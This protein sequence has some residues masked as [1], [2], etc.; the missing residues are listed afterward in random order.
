MEIR[1]PSHAVMK[2]T[3]SALPRAHT[4][5]VN[6]AT[7]LR[8]EAHVEHSIGLVQRQEGD[9]LCSTPRISMPYKC[10]MQYAVCSMP[11]A[12]CSMQ[13]AVCRMQYAV[14]SMQYAVQMGHS[15]WCDAASWYRTQS[16]SASLKHV[17]KPARCGHLGALMQR[18]QTN[19]L[20]R[21]QI[22]G[23]HPVH[24]VDRHPPGRIAQY[25]SV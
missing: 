2:A 10:S 8:F 20:I 16:D 15:V 17:N 1:W 25:N 14:C 21:K 3:D 18:K 11:Y 4:H 5:L 13:Y 6:D 22:P 12:V 19:T 23:F 24:E 7:H 9:V